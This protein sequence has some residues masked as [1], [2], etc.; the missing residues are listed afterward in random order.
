MLLRKALSRIF[1]L[2]S[3]QFL[4]IFVLSFRLQFQSGWKNDFSVLRMGKTAEKREENR[5][6]YRWH[7]RFAL[8]PNQKPLSG[9]MVDISSRGMA[10]L[11]H[12]DENCPKPD[13]I[14]S[15]NFGVPHF[16]SEDSF[17]TVFF[18]R[19]GRVCRVDSL[20]SK[21]NRIAVQ[22]EEPL[23]FKPGEQNISDFDAQK[24]LEAKAQSIVDIKEKP[25]PGGAEG[26]FTKTQTKVK[27]DTI[28]TEARKTERAYSEALARAEER[29]RSYAEAKAQAEEK[30][31]TEI[32]A[33]ARAEEQAKAE[34]KAR[35]EAE[36]K[37]KIEARLRAKAQ[38]KAKAEAEK[39]AKIEAELR[40]KSKRKP[41]TQP[42]K[43]I[44]KKN[45]Q[46]KTKQSG[47]VVLMEKIDKFITDRNKIF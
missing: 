36:T 6:R 20:T 44:E 38:K 8:N 7:A 46:D 18:N 10:L 11:Y 4:A 12:A 29:I 2:T 22:F 40:E 27:S 26:T 1:I 17:E 23:F 39:R 32:E 24:R 19:I 47:E 35:T 21:V 42:K 13:Q 28:K 30:L 37:A 41:K 16:D 43:A 14:I 15:T 3:K 45:T 34:T 31:R 9:Q 25:A 5:L 33:K